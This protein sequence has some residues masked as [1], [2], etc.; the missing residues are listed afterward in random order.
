[1]SH[2]FIPY[3]QGLEESIKKICRKYGIQ[4]YFKGNRTIKEMLVKPKHKDPLDKEWG[5]STGIS[6]G[7]LHVMRST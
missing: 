6:V 4:T 3:M 5:P 7:S 1:M 2:I